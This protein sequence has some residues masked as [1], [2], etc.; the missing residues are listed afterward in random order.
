MFGTNGRLILDISIVFYFITYFI[1]IFSLLLFYGWNPDWRQAMGRRPDTKRRVLWETETPWVRRLLELKKGATKT[2]SLVNPTAA[3]KGI[4]HPSFFV[5][6]LL[7]RM[8]LT[9]YQP[10][11]HGADHLHTSPPSPC[12][13]TRRPP[14]IFIGT[15]N[16]QDDRGFILAQ[17]IWAVERG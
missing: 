6:F 16:I 9:F 4:F 8:P 13:Q 17:A 10:I 12:R 14:G 2:R 3:N 5:L 15:L 7:T 11:P 1:I